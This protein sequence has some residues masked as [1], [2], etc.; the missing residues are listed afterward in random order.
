MTKILDHLFLGNVHNAQDT[1]F[2]KRHN[3]THIFQVASELRPKFPKKYQYNIIKI[4]DHNG[5]KIDEYF[6]SALALLHFIINENRTAPKGHSKD[7][8]EKLQKTKNGGQNILVHCNDGVSR[9]PTLIIAY[10]MKYQKMSFEEAFSYCKKL[11]RQSEPNRG[12]VVQ[13]KKFER[14]LQRENVGVASRYRNSLDILNIGTQGFSH[15]KFSK[16]AKRRKYSNSKG[17]H[18][19]KVTEDDDFIQSVLPRDNLN[20]KNLSKSNIQDDKYGFKYN[21]KQNG[22]APS[23]YSNSPQS[24]RIKKSLSKCSHGRKVAQKRSGLHNRLKKLKIKGSFSKSKPR[25]LLKSKNESHS[26]SSERSKN[27]SFVSIQSL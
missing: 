7:S 8:K 9:S 11:H 12:F 6:D 25:R 19:N 24:V 13:L 1:H 4:A 27:N 22:N 23:S 17:V 14:K 21:D 18:K 3:I 15:S 2:L 10:L 26:N 16:R 5:A 20:L